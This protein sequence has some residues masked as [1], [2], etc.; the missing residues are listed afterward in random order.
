M[1]SSQICA[2]CVNFPGKPRNFSHN[3]RRTTRFTH[4]K[5]DFAL[6]SAEIWRLT[7]ITFWLTKFTTFV[8]GHCNCTSQWLCGLTKI[9]CAPSSSL[10]F[11]RFWGLK[12]QP[13]FGDRTHIYEIWI[14]SLLVWLDGKR[15]YLCYHFCNLGVFWNQCLYKGKGLSGFT[16]VCYL[17]SAGCIGWVWKL[18]QDPNNFFDT[19]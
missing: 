16:V 19:V 2:Y 3:S 9:Y 10:S 17:C 1:T 15:I 5:C 18:S 4:T 14:V 8:V 7:L 11:I 6:K 13:D 12:L